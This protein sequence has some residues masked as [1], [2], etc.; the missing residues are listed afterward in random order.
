MKVVGT[1]SPTMLTIRLKTC[2]IPV[3]RD[4]LE[5]RR[6]VAIEA[7]AHA[8]ERATGRGATIA[9]SGEERATD[10]LV[11]ISR[12]LDDLRPRVH[13]DQP[14]ELVGPTWLLEEVIRGAAGEA[15]ERL[16][17]A[18]EAFRLDRDRITPD[19]VRGA[20]DAVC[21]STAT[22][23]GLDYAVNHAVDG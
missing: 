15:V 7:M 21:A 12:L 8:H 18:V 22:L 2:E 16:R 3:F 9:D 6:A 20:V 5:E 10:E 13:A 17:L 1:G 19:E 11:L 4:E 14:L 23:I